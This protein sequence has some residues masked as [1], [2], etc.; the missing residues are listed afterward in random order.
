M[1]GIKGHLNNGGLKLPR[2][3]D[4][5]IIVKFAAAGFGKDKLELLNKVRVHQ[6]VLFWS[7]VLGASGKSLDAKYMRKRE[8][9]ETWSKV[10]FPSEK[11]NQ[12]ST[13]LGGG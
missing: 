13:S 5:W 6:Q 1:F 4:Q 8:L 11:K 9:D 10:K 7:C 3:G 12:K 2:K